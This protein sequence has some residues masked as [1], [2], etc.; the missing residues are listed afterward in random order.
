[1]KK[2]LFLIILFIVFSSCKNNESSGGGE[3]HSEDPAIP[4]PTISITSPSAN[5]ITTSTINLQGACDNK[6][7]TISISGNISSPDKA[8]CTNSQFTV[9]ITLSENE[10]PKTI[11]VSQT[12]SSGTGSDSRTFSRR[13]LNDPL[14]IHAWHLKNSGQKSFSQ[15]SGTVGVDLNVE[16]V[17]NSGIK[18]QGVHVL[19]SDSGIDK[20][21]CYS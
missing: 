6:I 10:G 4:V 14:F 9:L 16:N 5:F 3:T 12:N 1:M 20:D 13:G 11:M 17:W 21:H 8:I 2:P 18:G 19:V 7:S 15:N